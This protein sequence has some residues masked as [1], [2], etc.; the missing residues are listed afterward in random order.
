VL[1]GS[2]SYQI[3]S[4]CFYS[5]PSF[6]SCSPSKRAIVQSALRV[7]RFLFSPLLFLHLR[8][9][10]RACLCRFCLSRRLCH[11]F[12]YDCDF[13]CSTSADTVLAFLQPSFAFLRFYSLFL[14]SVNP[15]D[16]CRTPTSFF[17]PLQ[18]K[19]IKP[20]GFE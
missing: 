18:W 20:S 2:G 15:F 12:R 6:H 9:T 5:S 3:P 10:R 7:P 19:F 4:P 16:V 11:R 13:F 8:F 14:G 1:Q 17:L